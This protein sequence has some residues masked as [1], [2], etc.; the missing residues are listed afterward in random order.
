MHDDA[1]DSD[2]SWFDDFDGRTI[3]KLTKDDDDI[4]NVIVSNPHTLDSNN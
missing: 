2:V 4:M 1:D 3:A